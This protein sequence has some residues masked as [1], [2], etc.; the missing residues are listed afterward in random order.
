MSGL[1]PISKVLTMQSAAAA[2]GNGTAFPTADY[3]TMGMQVTGTFVG[4]VTFEGTVDNT[5]W[6]AVQ[7]AN[8]NDGSVTTTAT[9]EGIFACSVAGLRQVRARISDWTS[10]TITVVG[11]GTSAGGGMSLADIDVAASETVVLG[12]GA[13]SIGKLGAN[14]GVDIG[15]VDVTSIAAGET[16]IG[17]VGGSSI[18]VSVTPAITS[19]AYTAN[20]IVGAVQTI[21]NA[22]RSS[23]KPTILQSITIT[24]L[25]AQSNAFSIYFFHTTPPNGTYTDNLALTIHDT[26]M[27]FCVGVVKVLASDYSAASASSV[28][29]VDGIGLLMT[30]AATSLF[31]IAQCT[32]TAPTY[33]STGDL[34]FK[35]GFLRD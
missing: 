15:D 34:T 19:G 29:T 11:F 2:T 1:L 22:A 14:S 26:D 5:N 12:A 16:H 32:G 7:V 17:E 6:V 8:L 28:A 3:A 27:G 30:P 13:A 25:G 21:A 35:Y 9:A 33:T 20:D 18:V 4:T 24:D 10:G 31:A 23:A